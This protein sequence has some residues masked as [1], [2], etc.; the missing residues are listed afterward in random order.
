MHVHHVHGC[1]IQTLMLCT[2]VTI[3]FARVS[4]PLLPVL[5]ASCTAYSQVTE[6]ASSGFS[7]HW[8]YHR[9]EHMHPTFD[10]SCSGSSLSLFC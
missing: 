10:Q 9:N 7:V 1:S 6:E 2:N 3:I 5:A 4:E 8:R